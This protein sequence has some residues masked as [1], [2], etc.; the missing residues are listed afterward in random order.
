MIS[1]REEIA[2]TIRRSGFRATPQRVA[3]YEALWNAGSHPSVADIHEHATKADPSISLATVY[4]TLQLF[5]D[6]GLVREMGAKEGSTRYDPDTDFHI[7]LVCVRCGKVE[8]FDCI[9]IEQ[10]APNIDRDTGFRVQSY[11]FEVKGLCSDCRKQ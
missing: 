10:I 11:N 2:D 4:K 1:S 8:D 9:S 7:N 3:I 5:V 6:I